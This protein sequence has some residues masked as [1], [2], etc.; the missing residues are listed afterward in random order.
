MIIKNSQQDIIIEED[1][2]IKTV[3]LKISGGADSAIVA[4]MLSKFVVEERPDIKII[5]ITTT[6]KGK[7]F[8]LVYSKRVIEF[9]K[10]EFGDVFTEHHHNH[11]KKGSEYVP[12]QQILVD[13]LRATTD[14]V[15]V[16][17][18][19][20]ANPPREIYEQWKP[21][22]GPT[23]NRNGKNFPTRERGHRSPLINIDKKGVAELYNTLGVM[24]TLFPITRSC[25]AWDKWENYDF[26]KHCEI[27][28]W[29]KERHWGFGKYK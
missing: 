1:E 2:T 26:E 5:P 4:Y 25:E 18:G 11:A 14:M 16:Y 8:Q 23:D 21:W 29:C 17:V 7:P 6:L 28:W 27:C 19:I 10:N 13:S 20:T 24:D 9:L 3:G 22:T 12:T 15:H